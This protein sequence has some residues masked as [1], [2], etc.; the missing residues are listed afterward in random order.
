MSVYEEDQKVYEP[1]WPAF[2][3]MI[4]DALIHYALPER[5]SVGPR[6]LLFA[7]I[8]V[9]LIPITFT[10]RSGRHDVTRILTFIV[11]GALTVALIGSLGADGRRTYRI[12]KI[13]RELC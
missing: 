8:F 4:A 2:I 11:L 9:L 6:W 1:I 3:A 12:T 13:R 5:L 7:V 10:H